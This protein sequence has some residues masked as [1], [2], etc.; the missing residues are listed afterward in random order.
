MNIFTMQRRL[1]KWT[2]PL[3]EKI[4]WT[5]ANWPAIVFT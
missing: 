2:Y 5:F 1:F 3:D 4:L